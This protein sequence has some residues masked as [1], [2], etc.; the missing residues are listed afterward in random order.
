MST[1]ALLGFRPHTYWTA[2][3]A[4]AG[5]AEAPEVL[6]RR[7]LVFAG[8][9][10]KFAYHRAA[11]VDPAT[12]AAVIERARAGAEARAER[13]IRKL[14][15][16]LARE[17]VTVLAA[18]TA[19]ATAKLPGTLADVLGSHTRIHAAE[20]IF[21]REVIAAACAAAGLEV[22][23]VVEHE[24]AALTADLLGGGPQA[25]AA[26]LKGMGTAL[27]PPWSEDFKL[28]VEAAWLHLPTRAPA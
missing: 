17:G 21:A 16:E 6:D 27:G 7:R 11:E 4:V 15:D 22:H 10:E 24:L 18:A 23:R 26:R 20:G 12:A 5:T 1:F 8:P 25:V 28:A 14:L 3:A 13:E 19:A 9:D 2:V